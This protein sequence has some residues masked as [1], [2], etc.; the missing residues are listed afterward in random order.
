MVF[1]LGIITDEVADDLDF[2]LERIRDWGLGSI[3]LRTVGGQ[4]LVSLDDETVSSA[5]ASF[6]TAELKPSLNQAY[7]LARSRA[8]RLPAMSINVAPDVHSRVCSVSRQL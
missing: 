4:N 2:A 1:E 7:I 6:T 8:E 5:V 3:E